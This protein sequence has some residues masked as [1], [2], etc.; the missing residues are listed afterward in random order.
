[1]GSV[2]IL[3]YKLSFAIADGKGWPICCSFGTLYQAMLLLQ[4]QI[5]LIEGVD[6]INH[7]LHQFNLG[8]AQPMLV[9]DVIGDTSLTT[10]FAA[11]ATGLHLQLFA[12]S[13]QG[14]QTLLGPARQ[15]NMDRC[16]HASA[17]VCWARMEVAKTGAQHEIL[18]RLG[19]NRVTNSLDATGKS[20]KNSTNITT[21]LHGDDAKLILL[22]DPG[23]ESLGF[24][25]EDATAL[26]PVTLHASSDRVSVS[27]NEK[28]VVVNQL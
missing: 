21:G 25:V 26:R 1:M 22:I 27:R 8:V 12:P 16:A 18:A 3:L 6:T 10:R 28:E 19:L 7:A 24:I 14:W 15:V 4:S 17:Q 5:L 9:G 20:F 13:L 23:E 11:C 2:F